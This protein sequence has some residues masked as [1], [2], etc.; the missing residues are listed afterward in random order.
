MAPE[1]PYFPNATN[2]FVIYDRATDWTECFPQMTLDLKR[3]LDS[4]RKFEGTSAG[5]TGR[6]KSF[7]ADNFPSITQACKVMNWVNPHSDPGVPQS[8]G[9]AESMVRRVKEGGR[10][11]TTRTC[12]LRGEEGKS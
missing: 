6:V 3:T 9:L 8:N 1:D 10:S 12:L 5:T 7:Y 4:M 11:S 2:A